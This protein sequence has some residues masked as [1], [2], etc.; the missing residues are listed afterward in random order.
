MIRWL[1]I[2]M[3]MALSVA[4]LTDLHHQ[5]RAEV[6]EVSGKLLTVDA[7]ERI[8]SIQGKTLEVPKKCVVVIDGETADLATLK[9][10]QVAVVKYDDA[11]EVA[12]SIAVGDS[13]QSG[14]LEAIPL[15]NG[16]NLS[17]WRYS[18]DEAKVDKA[19]SV[20]QGGVLQC[21]GADDVAPLLTDEKY[22]NFTIA[23][24]WR[25]PPGVQPTVDGLGL[26]LRINDR[27]Q[28]FKK[29]VRFQLQDRPDS[30]LWIIGQSEPPQ[31]LLGKV[32]K[33]FKDPLV[34]GPKPVKRPLGT[35]NTLT[36]ICD[37][38]EVSVEQNGKE[39]I[40][41]RGVDSVAGYI[42]FIPAK[43]KTEVRKVMLTPK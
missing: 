10:G 32:F 43:T 3:T 30:A 39:T 37:G 1:P 7:D 33:D 19:W 9:V 34:K 26:A 29:Q 5:V 15:F 18:G 27:E 24:E 16:R 25:F 38:E 4:H 12:T 6:L 8:I 13:P 36:I 14:T 2:A 20:Q 28:I 41:V 42:G 11:L 23:L 40:H 17:G 31:S 22:K 35:W 21:S